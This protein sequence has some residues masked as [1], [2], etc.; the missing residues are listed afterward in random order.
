M[1]KK[2]K[3]F[4]VLLLLAYFTLLISGCGGGNPEKTIESVIGGLIEAENKSIEAQKNNDMETSAESKDDA[5]DTESPSGSTSTSAGKTVSHCEWPSNI[6]GYVPQLQGDIAAVVE[7]T[8]EENAKAI[9]IAYENVNDSGAD[10]YE[11]EL[12]SKGWT[13]DSKTNMGEAWMIIAGY[14]DEARIN[15]GVENEEN[16]GMITLTILY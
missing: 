15:V 4:G 9:T 1:R 13:I 8:P 14:K 2:S 6:P 5:A 3:M 16:S 11:K 7:M 10:A 12:L